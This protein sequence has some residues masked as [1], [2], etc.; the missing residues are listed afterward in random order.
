MH[1][2]Q[3]LAI[4]AVWRELRDA[5]PWLQFIGKCVSGPFFAYI[6]MMLFLTRNCPLLSQ[7][8]S[9]E[10]S[11]CVVLRAKTSCRPEIWHY[12]FVHFAARQDGWA[13]ICAL[14]ISCLEEPFGFVSIHAIKNMTPSHHYTFLLIN[15][16]E[17]CHWLPSQPAS[18]WVSNRAATRTM[19]E[20][21][22]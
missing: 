17:N 1:F 21:V 8:R 15:S 10:W 13:I 16:R 14:I 18:R 5:P 20:I 6:M 4:A 3:M 7:R 9:S 2:L 11:F 19:E 22:N 12:C